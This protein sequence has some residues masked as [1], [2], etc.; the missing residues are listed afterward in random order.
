DANAAV[1]TLRRVRALEDK[2]YGTREHRDAATSDLL[3]ARAL[4]V[5]GAAGD[6]REARRL[7]DEGLAVFAR[8]H[9][10]DVWRAESLLESGRL[11]LAEGDH[12]RAL[13]D[14]AAAEPLLAARK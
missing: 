8:V 10:Q 7:L 12:D 5:R 11:A 9:P 13:H 4:L 2:L 3:L 14:L 6:A 1:G